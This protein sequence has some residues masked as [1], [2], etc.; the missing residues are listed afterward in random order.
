MA[1]RLGVLVFGCTQI[2]V[3]LNADL[4][5]GV[6][7]HPVTRHEFANPAIESVLSG[8]ISESEIFGKDSTIKARGASR[9]GENNLDL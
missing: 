8:E 6:N 9:A 3:L 5:A 4:P 7:L 1:L 2:P